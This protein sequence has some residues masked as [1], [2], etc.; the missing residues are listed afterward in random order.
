MQRPGVLAE[1][2]LD[3]YLLRLLS[4][5]QVWLSNK[6]NNRETD[7]EDVATTIALVDEWGRGFVN[8]VDYLA[9]ARNTKD[10]SR[11]MRDRGLDAVLAPRVIDEL[12]TSNILVTE[13]IDGTRL[14]ASAS[15]D[16]PRLCGVAINAYLTMLLDSGVLHC[17]PHPGNLLRT[18][19]GQLCI[20]DFG[21]TLEVPANLRY[22]LLEFIA[23]VNS[24]NLE[25][26]PSDFVN[27]GFTPPEKLEKVRS[28][29]ITDGLSFMLRQLS[30]GGGPSKIRERVKAEFV[31]RYGDISDEELRQKAR[32]EMVQR[33]EDQLQKEGVDVRGVSN[34]MEEMSRRN[35]ELFRLPSW[36]LYTVRAFSTLEGIGLSVNEDYAI[37]QECYPY[38]ARRLFTDNSPRAK[39]ALEAMLSN[40][41]PPAGASGKLAMSSVGPGL[42]LDKMV[43]MA[44]GFTS[45]TVSTTAVGDDL[46][47]NTLPASGGDSAKSSSSSSLGLPKTTAPAVA[48]DRALVEAQKELVGVLLAKNG[49]VAQ[50]LVVD[51]AT[52][53]V[54]ATVRSSVASLV[55]ASGLTTEDILD[56]NDEPLLRPAIRALRSLPAPARLG[57]LPLTAPVEAAAAVANVLAPLVAV[58]DRDR[59]ALKTLNTLAGIADRNGVT[60]QAG[61]ADL[62]RKLAPEKLDQDTV[63]SVGILGR[64]FAA[65]LLR[66]AAGRLDE[67]HLDSDDLHLLDLPSVQNASPFERSLSKA[68]ASTLAE[69]YRQAARALSPD[70]S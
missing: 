5:L 12:T 40:G 65:T 22:S 70:V 69:S 2:C 39:A 52:R 49:S 50:K 48:N 23:H 17:D 61:A 28:S 15:P 27:L 44:E 14:D 10:F 11:A 41:K 67:G 47:V 25:A 34:V 54:D 3:L 29:G 30:A 19:D 56:S 60:S 13:W 20:L 57:L 26:I 31:E 42:N 24:E 43:E 59:A 64:R 6:I 38:L 35:R 68:T 66:R 58:D 18:R 46:L 36:V 21:M 37:L 9:E 16:V 8:E 53:L 4:P 33:M 55:D 1:I 32:A 7:P 45:Y 62:V 63:D 51:E